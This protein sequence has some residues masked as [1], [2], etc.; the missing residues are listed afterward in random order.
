MKRLLYFFLLAI[1]YLKAE[2][3][4]QPENVVRP[5]ENINNCVDDP[6]ELE[7]YIAAFPEQDYI[8]CYVPYQGT[9]YVEPN[10]HDTIKNVLR[11]GEK[12]EPHILHMINNYAKPGTVVL[13]IGSHIG[14]FT[15]AMS[16]AVGKNGTVHAFEPQRKIY[17]ELRKNCELNGIKNAVCHRLA[18]G[19]RPQIIEMDIETYLGSEGSTGIG[20]GG[21]RAEMRTIDSFNFTNVSFVKI[22]VERTEEQVLDGMVNTILNNK[23]VIVI[24]LQGGYLW[25]SAPPDIRQKMLNSIEKLEKL[26]Y[27]VTRIYLHDYLALP[28]R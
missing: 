6:Q 25:E 11:S 24:E 14:T 4:L 3:E 8:T 19:D 5:T 10:R 26:G 16:V 18:I 21:D 27:V 7:Q 2:P 9:F 1:S 17:R 15:L 13:D 12:W 28:T 22:D 23:P 20:G